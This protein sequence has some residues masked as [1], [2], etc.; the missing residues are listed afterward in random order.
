MYSVRSP[1][2]GMDDCSI[3]PTTA[4]VLTV[5]YSATVVAFQPCSVLHPAVYPSAGILI[6]RFA[7]ILMFGVLQVSLRGPRDFL[8]AF[9]VG[10]SGS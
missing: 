10:S 4:T 9:V 3:L 5:N 6:R 7:L 8:A 1:T 2:L